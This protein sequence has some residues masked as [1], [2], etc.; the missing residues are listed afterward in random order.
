MGPARP[1]GARSRPPRPLH[2]RGA[3]GP[4]ARGLRVDRRRGDGPGGHAA[5]RPLP[6]RIAGRRPFPCRRRGRPP[7]REPRSPRLPFAARA[8]SAIGE[9]PPP[10]GKPG[11]MAAVRRRPPRVSRRR[12]RN[13]RA[14]LR[15]LRVPLFRRLRRRDGGPAQP[16]GGRGGAPV[17]RIRRPGAD[18]S[19][20]AP[21]CRGRRVSRLGGPVRNHSAARVPKGPRAVRTRTGRRRFLR[22]DH[23]PRGDRHKIGPAGGGQGRISRVAPRAPPGEPLP[24]GSGVS[25]V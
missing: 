3:M 22:D 24:S 14:G 12:L 10:E 13:R 8:R 16:G 23:P 15:P 6:A 11:R 7:V 5:R 20:G 17:G 25:P 18:S 4:H 2:R 21:G 19:G 1:L 9:V